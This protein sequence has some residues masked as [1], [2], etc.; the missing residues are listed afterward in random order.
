MLNGLIKASAEHQAHESRR[1]AC[2]IQTLVEPCAEHE[3]LEGGWPLDMVDVLVEVLQKDDALQRL[4]PHDRIQLLVE[5]LA[6]DQLLQTTTQDLPTNTRNEKECTGH[7]NSPRSQ[8]RF[9]TLLI[10]H[11]AG[12]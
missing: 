1:E 9:V 3:L 2:P 6:E 5:G 12:E 8:F 10:S 7:E 4:G 11:L